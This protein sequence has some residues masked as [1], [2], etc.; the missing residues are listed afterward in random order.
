MRISFLKTR[1]G[2]RSYQTQNKEEIFRIAQLKQTL[3]KPLYKLHDL[4]GRPL[5]GFFYE[6]EI[7]RTDSNYHRVE[8]ILK[9]TKTKYFVKFVDYDDSH[10]CWIDRQDLVEYANK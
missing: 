8:K 6:S 3:P 7:I 2:R 1:F 4:L 5:A 9:K 10:N